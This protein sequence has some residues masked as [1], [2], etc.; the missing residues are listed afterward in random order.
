MYH[1]Y[2]TSIEYNVYH[3]Y[4]TQNT[5]GNSDEIQCVSR[6]KTSIEYYVYHDAKQNRIQCVDTKQYRTQCVDTKDRKQCVS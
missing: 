4:Q 6:Y 2:Q 3:G 1:G 5:M